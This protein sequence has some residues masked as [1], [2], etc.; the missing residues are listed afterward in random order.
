MADLDTP[1]SPVDEEATEWQQQQQEEGAET[2]EHVEE[3]ADEQPPADED[4]EARSPEPSGEAEHAEAP[5]E[6]NERD[7][8]EARSPDDEPPA[9]ESTTPT[10]KSPVDEAANT[11]AERLERRQVA[12]G[13]REGGR[14]E[15][16]ADTRANKLMDDIFGENLDVDD[17]SDAEGAP[18]KNDRKRA[19]A[20][21]SSDEDGGFLRPG[22]ADS[23]D[24]RPQHRWDFDEMMAKKKKERKRTKR[25]RRDGTYDLIS[26]ADDHIKE[27]VDKMTRAAED[28]RKSNEQRQPAFQKQKLL[29][30]VKQTL[31]RV[32]WF[33]ALL[34]NGMM[35][36]VSEWLA[37]LPD[38]SLSSLE[39]RTTLLKILHDFPN[40]EQGILRQS[41]LGKA[42]MYLL[43]H[44][45]ESKE[46]KLRAAKLIREWSR[47]IFQ[48]SPPLV[49]LCSLVCLQLESDY[50][51]MSREKRYERDFNQMKKKKR[52]DPEDDD[53][54]PSSSRSQPAG[55]GDA[56]ADGE[57]GS[58]SMPG[59]T[60]F[61]PRARVPKPSMKAY[62]NRPPPAVEGRFAGP[63]KGRS[64]NRFEIAQREFKERTKTRKAR[65]HIGVSIA[66]NKMEI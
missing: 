57:A 19:A 48:V 30:V 50:T 17:D 21:D 15:E 32:D 26:D 42:V 11:S 56:A 55:G 8:A 40:L 16:D 62:V 52:R 36:A 22:G 33:E 58:S 59:Q 65:R 51:S 47:P 14:A 66:G 13:R 41:G 2:P 18:A 31:L 10:P 39:I 1:A 5:I 60:G 24:E 45:R 28:D 61:V 34:D 54:Q 63:S 37:P 27:V 12:A 38:K 46:N 9:A 53:S 44:P 64:S 3:S 4:N 49:L 20:A 7:A 29:P 43:K 25:R 23:G 6:I 35:S